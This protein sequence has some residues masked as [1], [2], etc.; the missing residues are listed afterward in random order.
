MKL[1]TIGAPIARLARRPACL[2]TPCLR[3]GDR[4]ELEIS[5]LGVQ[6]Q[7]LAEA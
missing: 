7:T 1:M 2:Q 6:T 3:P 4:V 5:G